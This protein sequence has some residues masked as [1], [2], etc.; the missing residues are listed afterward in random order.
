MKRP[1]REASS[2]EIEGYSKRIKGNGGIGQWTRDRG[3]TWQRGK[4]LEGQGRIK[5]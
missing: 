2:K 1:G 5:G 4:W 3:G